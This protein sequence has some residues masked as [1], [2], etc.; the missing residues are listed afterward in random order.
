MKMAKGKVKWFNPEKGY[1]F[2][3]SEDGT[4]VFAHFSAIQMD[5]YKTLEE[6][7]EV[8]LVDHANFDES[9][10]SLDKAK[11][12]K[13]VDHHRVALNTSYPLYYRAEPVG[14]TETVMYKLYKENE[15]KIDKTICNSTE[16]RQLEAKKMS[17]ECDVMLIIWQHLHLVFVCF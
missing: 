13:I 4:D 1:G 5:G 12:L 15:V 7:A 10:P 14:C 8:I 9:V 3:E 6:G 16:N 11:I 17:R 2:I